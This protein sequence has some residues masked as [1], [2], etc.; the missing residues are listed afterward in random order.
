ME[1]SG[2]SGTKSVVS[3]VF[4]KTVVLPPICY[5]TYRDPDGK[6]LYG[7]ASTQLLCAFLECLGTRESGGVQVQ[8]LLSL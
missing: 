1:A 4:G 6:I 2:K 3:W 7:G 8:D 5:F